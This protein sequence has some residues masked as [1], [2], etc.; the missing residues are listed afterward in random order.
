[1]SG[2]APALTERFRAALALA[3][4]V[5]G[6]TRRS[7]T[8]IPYLAH[9]LVVTGLVL[10][11]GGDEDEAIAAI[12]HDSVED[13][14]G[15]PLLE[16]IRREFGER[17]AEIVEQLSDSIET[18]TNESWIDRKR[19]YLEDLQECQDE[20]ALRVS[21]ADKLNNARAIVREYRAEGDALWERFAEKTADQQ[22]W[23]YACLVEIF[24][25]KRPGPL[26]EDLRRAFD[27]LR[28]LV[29]DR[30]PEA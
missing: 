18:D 13:G 11:D 29:A 19:R 8:E 21:L 12:L 3:E 9:L 23:Y 7:G 27:E 10:E 22:L 2:A 20:A 16:R 28:A 17:V 6:R 25:A 5:H 4:E 30:E 1:V 14:G 15:R 26:T 24:E